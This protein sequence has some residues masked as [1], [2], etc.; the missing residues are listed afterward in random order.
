LNG[1]AWSLVDKLD[2][3]YDEA[4]RYAIAAV[5]ADPD[6]AAIVDTLAWV[7]YKQKRYPEALREQQRAVRLGERTRNPFEMAELYYHLGA[8]LEK[9]DRRSEAIQAYRMSVRARPG[10][11]F[12]Q[13]QDALRRLVPGYRPEPAPPGRRD[14]RS[15]PWPGFGPALPNPFQPDRAP[16]PIPTPRR[17]RDPQADTGI[18]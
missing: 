10:F 14:P 17:S 2:R 13:S 11:P 18:L 8:I 16:D 12:P 9:V 7:Y 6:N 1:Y 5:K 15:S 3:D 4:E